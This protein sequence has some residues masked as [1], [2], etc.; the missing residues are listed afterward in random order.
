MDPTTNTPPAAAPAPIFIQG[1]RIDSL[2][3]DRDETTGE[4]KIEAAY[5]LVS[6]TGRVLAKQSVGGY[7]GIKLQP[8]PATLKA[9]AAAI[10]AYKNDVNVTLGLA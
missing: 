10:A 3:I 1:I 8:S 2:K 6:S 7:N 5:A 9:F 4:D